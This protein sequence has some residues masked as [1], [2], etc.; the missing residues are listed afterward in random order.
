MFSAAKLLVLAPHPDDGELGAGGLISKLC[1]AGVEKRYVAFS[2]CVESVPEG[3]SS[4]VL[5][6]EARKATRCLGFLEEELTVL[7]FPVR[8]FPRYRQEILEWLVKLKREFAPNMVLVPASYDV[9]QDH[10]VIYQE[11]KRAFKEY[12]I[13]GYELPWNC[14]EFRADLHVELAAENIADK[15]Q[16]I[17]CYESQSFRGYGDGMLLKRLAELRGSQIGAT[18]AEAFQVIHWAWRLE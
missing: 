8:H 4:D 3:F 10:N 16:A 15:M 6:A 2:S 11:A 18:Y 5:V 12:T 17:G 9:H 14:Y 1:R 13:L 7:D